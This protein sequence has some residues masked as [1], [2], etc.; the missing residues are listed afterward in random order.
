MIKYTFQGI[1]LFYTP[2]GIIMGYPSVTVQQL[3]QTLKGWRKTR[4]MTQIE[5][6][7]KVGLL[8]KTISGLEST[9]A[10]STVGSLFK[11]ISALDLEVVIQPKSKTFSRPTA[12]EW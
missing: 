3:A 8:P 2:K 10:E 1:I 5:A 7:S 12:G 4:K 9:P 11:L 6:G